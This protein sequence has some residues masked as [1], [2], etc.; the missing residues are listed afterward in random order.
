MAVMITGT[1]RSCQSFAADAVHMR[2]TIKITGRLLSR[3]AVHDVWHDAHCI[4]EI[5]LPACTVQWQSL[6]P[7]PLPSP[8]GSE[9]GESIAPRRLLAVAP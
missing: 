6:S 3:L 4:A 5:G 7:P 9:N 8:G 1:G 2:F